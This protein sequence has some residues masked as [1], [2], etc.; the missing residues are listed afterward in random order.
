MKSG[1]SFVS[2]VGLSAVLAMG[3]FGCVNTS[4]NHDGQ[5]ST[6]VLSG[7]NAE[8]GKSETL[9][10]R[11]SAS[12]D[13]AKSVGGGGRQLAERARN[14][15]HGEG[16]YPLPWAPQGAGAMPGHGFD[17]PGVTNEHRPQGKP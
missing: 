4:S 10:D 7:S 17:R 2:L 9:R 1:K 8:G 16:P 14:D 3:A 6:A 5:Q 15:G 13:D 12:S 11:E